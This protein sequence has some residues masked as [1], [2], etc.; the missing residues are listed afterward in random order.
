MTNR[1]EKIQYFAVCAK[2]ILLCFS[3]STH[4]ILQ[5]VQQLQG[6]YLITSETVLTSHITSQHAEDDVVDKV[7][8][9][10][11]FTSYVSFTAIRG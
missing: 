11:D 4:T 9:H 3:D 10:W 1:R 2:H 7:H 6:F 5:S 8:K